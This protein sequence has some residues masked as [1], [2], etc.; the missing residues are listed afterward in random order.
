MDEVTYLVILPALNGCRQTIWQLI[1]ANKPPTVPFK[2][3]HHTQILIMF[4]SESDK[5][6]P[7]FPDSNFSFSHEHKFKFLW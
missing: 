4:F 5:S 7:N 6:K 2:E 3:I 1:L